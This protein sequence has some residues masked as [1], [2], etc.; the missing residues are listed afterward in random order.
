MHF[1]GMIASGIN[2]Y[3]F[4]LNVIA[5]FLS[6][7][8]SV[9]GAMLA[10][11]ILIQ[12]NVK[13]IFLIM[14]SVLMGGSIA[15]MHY[16]GMYAVQYDLHIEHHP[17]IIFLSIAIAVIGSFI[18]L[19]IFSKVS[20]KYLYIYQLPIAIILGL[21]VSIM[22]YVAMESYTLYNIPY[23]DSNLIYDHTF[24]I[25]STVMLN[26]LIG[27]YSI[28]FIITYIM[29]IRNKQMQY[30]MHKMAFYDPVTNL[31]NRN[32]LDHHF[33]R[34]IQSSKA[35]TKTFAV[36]FLDLDDFKLVN[37]KYGHEVGDRFLT[38]I[39]ETLTRVLDDDRVIISRHG[40]D[41]FI[42]LATKTDK[43]S[44]LLLAEKIR[45]T[46]QNPIVID[47]KSI[48]I[49]FSIGISIY[50]KDGM[51]MET[52]INQADQAMYMA[53]SEGKNDVSLSGD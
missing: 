39:A 3:N 24:S 18:S 36:F 26:I 16:V 38:Q 34:I 53:K 40:G 27:M 50:P 15:S 1:T 46:F 52:L 29:A 6:L 49:S 11:R 10:F 9:I 17:S 22:H 12:R 13:F 35:R 47:G 4:Q 42:I 21:A 8:V 37:D 5:T 19:F 48:T 43:Q 28:I 41:E 2:D 20:D 45:G 14:A 44:A 25:N 51:D 23:Q 33:Q 7:T 32:L 31:P 30:Q